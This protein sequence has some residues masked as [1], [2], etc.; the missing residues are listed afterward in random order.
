MFNY[1][2]ASEMRV[3]IVPY[4][5]FLRKGFHNYTRMARNLKLIWLYNINMAFTIIY[6]LNDLRI[7]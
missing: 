1:S 4:G 5:E 2:K 6:L 3:T 7:T